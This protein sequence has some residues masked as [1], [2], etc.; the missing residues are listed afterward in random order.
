MK[1]IQDE[2]FDEYVESY[3]KLTLIDKQ[4]EI[5]NEFKKILGFLD[6]LNVNSGIDSSMLYNREILDTQK[7]YTEDD[8]AECVFVY[9]HALEEYLADY[10]N[11]IN[12]EV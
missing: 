4:K 11:G 5:E 2:T 7:E 1:L 8:F 9:L 10:I 3:K 6:Q 12:K